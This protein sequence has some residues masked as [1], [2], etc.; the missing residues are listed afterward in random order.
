MVKALLRI[1]LIWA[2]TMF[3]APY[4]SRLLDRLARK[5]PR[6]SFLEEMLLEFSGQ[7]SSSLVHSFGETLGELVLGSGKR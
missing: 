6:G 7:Y 5:A 1:A 2:M 4:V 3:L